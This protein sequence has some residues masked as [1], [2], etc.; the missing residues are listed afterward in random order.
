MM[1]VTCPSCGSQL[2]LLNKEAC[3][4]ADR[5]IEECGPAV[6]TLNVEQ[7]WTKEGRLSV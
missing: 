1:Y 4:R 2:P 5:H 3:E 7:K 6:R